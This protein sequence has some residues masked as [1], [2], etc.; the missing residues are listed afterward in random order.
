MFSV[1][2]FLKAL[3]FNSE[4]GE[5]ATNASKARDYSNLNIHVM[6]ANN[7]GSYKIVHNSPVEKVFTKSSNQIQA[8]KN[9][10]KKATNTKQK[11]GNISNEIDS[12]NDKRCAKFTGQRDAKN[13]QK[14]R[15]RMERVKRNKNVDFNM[16]VDFNKNVDFT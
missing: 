1:D 9:R 16:N 7:T 10:V 8:E 4:Q 5:R 14:R 12:L 2:D 15:A 13:E 6:R 3:E 11:S